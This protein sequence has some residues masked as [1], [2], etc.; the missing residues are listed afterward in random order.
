M[1]LLSYNF[2]SPPAVPRVERP[3]TVQIVLGVGAAGLFWLILA[4][5]TRSHI[6]YYPFMLSF[7]AQLAIIGS[8]RH[9][10]VAQ[11]I[12]IGQLFV[13]SVLIGWLILFVPF[14]VL[15]TSTRALWFDAVVGLVAVAIGVAAF[16]LSQGKDG[17]GNSPQRW[18]LQSLSAGL[19]SVLG[20]A[21]LQLA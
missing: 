16:T 18:L 5:I 14:A 15:T 2:L 1:L 11:K 7:A 21:A 12:S 6:L 19:A 3:H 4:S 13:K 10:R 20:F 8:S 9:L 17:Y